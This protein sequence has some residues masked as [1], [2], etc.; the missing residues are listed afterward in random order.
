MSVVAVSG[1]GLPLGQSIASAALASARVRRLVVLELSPEAAV[2]F[3]QACFRVGAHCG[4]DDYLQRLPAIL[5]EEGVDLYI[6]GSE[7]EMLHLARHRASF[8]AAAGCRLAAASADAL[9]TGGD[10]LRTARL[11]EQAGLPF[12]RTVAVGEAAQSFG[13]GAFPLIAKGR[14]AGAPIVVEDAEDLAYVRRKH[15]DYVVQEF[16]GRPGDAEFT[17]GVYRTAREGVVA[18]FGLRRELR[19][20]LTWRAVRVRDAAFD[21]AVTAAAEALGAE[22]P[23]NVQFRLRDGVPV[24]HE[25]NVRCSSTTAFRAMMGWNEVD[26]MLDHFV[27]G[28]P[29]AVPALAE[30]D[31]AIAVRAFREH[32]HDPGARA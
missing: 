17:Y 19:Y 13:P 4:A 18:V 32:W 14:T 28:R 27:D 2:L 24:V 6:P 25:F 16:L 5:R 3:P 11:L 31:D 1:I 22:G 9:E 7:R 15:P 30:A 21:A 29:P 8:E 26:M 10:K 23:V 12:P 20:G